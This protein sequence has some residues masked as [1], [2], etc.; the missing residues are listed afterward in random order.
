MGICGKKYCA[1]T[2]VYMP[3][4]NLEIKLGLLNFFFD[5]VFLVEISGLYNFTLINF[6]KFTC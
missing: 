5:F 1:L 3:V 4:Y 6:L 2:F